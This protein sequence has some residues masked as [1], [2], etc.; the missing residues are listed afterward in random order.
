MS[1]LEQGIAEILYNS[2]G[3]NGAVPVQAQEQAIPSARAGNHRSRKGVGC[4]GAEPGCIASGSR[5]LRRCT[6]K[7][8]RLAESQNVP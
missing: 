7:Q 1:D 4:C 5:W 3:G 2:N 8:S 6:P